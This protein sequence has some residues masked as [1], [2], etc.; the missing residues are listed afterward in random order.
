M[1]TLVNAVLFVMTLSNGIRLLWLKSTSKKA[2]TFTGK[3]PGQSGYPTEM[4][5]KMRH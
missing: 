3:N 4:M 5:G 1:E 2:G